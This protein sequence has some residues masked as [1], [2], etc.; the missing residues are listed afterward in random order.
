MSFLLLMTYFLLG[1]CRIPRTELHLIL[2]VGSRGF[3]LVWALPSLK[4]LAYGAPF[5]KMAYNAVGTEVNG[6]RIRGPYWG[7]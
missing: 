5:W 4:A 1:E 2:W 3:G 7:P 6:F